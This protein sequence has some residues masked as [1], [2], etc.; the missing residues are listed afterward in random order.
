MQRFD[1]LD[2]DWS[3]CLVQL[4]LEDIP[5]DRRSRGSASTREL[6]SELVDARIFDIEGSHAP[7]S[8]PKG[9]RQKPLLSAW[10][11]GR[12]PRLGEFAGRA[13]WIVGG[14][15]RRHGRH[16]CGARFA[17]REGVAGLHSPDGHARQCRSRSDLRESRISQRR[18]MIRLGNG[19]P[20]CPDAQI[21]DRPRTKRVDLV[22]VGLLVRRQPDDG[23]R[24]DDLANRRDRKVFLP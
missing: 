23:V 21:V 7:N 13:S 15:Y 3:R 6:C 22:E 18:G 11:L 2:V 14:A 12:I 4:F 1:F 19:F 8:T 24:S 16:S 20:D 9:R 10:R 17:Q 5:N